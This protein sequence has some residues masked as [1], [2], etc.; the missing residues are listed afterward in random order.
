[1]PLGM[2]EIGPNLAEVLNNLAVGV[3]MVIFA[4]IFYLITKH[5]M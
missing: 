5:L 3:G 1:M 4:Y 2:L